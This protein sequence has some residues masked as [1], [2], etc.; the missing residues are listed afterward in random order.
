MWA[1]MLMFGRHHRHHVNMCMRLCFYDSTIYD[2]VTSLFRLQQVFSLY[3]HFSWDYSHIW[4]TL[5]P[6]CK[7]LCM[8]FFLRF[9]NLK[10]SYLPFS[11]ENKYSPYTKSLHEFN[12][13]LGKY[14]H[15]HVGHH[16]NV[17]ACDFIYYSTI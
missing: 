3:G 8:H 10:Q 7:H 11:T 16:V 14:Y 15:H 1:T 4:Y 2:R 17:H 6:P 12:S 13:I 9:D 5:L